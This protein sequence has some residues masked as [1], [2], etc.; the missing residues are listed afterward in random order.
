MRERQ[1]KVSL[2]VHHKSPKSG[3]II[4]TTPYRLV[5]VGNQRYYEMPTGSGSFF[6]ENAKPV[7]EANLPEQCKRLPA[8]KTPLSQEQEMAKMRE[9]LN[10]IQNENTELAQAKER[11]EAE[12]KARDSAQTDSKPASPASPVTPK[13]KTA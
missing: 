12:A 9:V 11:L 3:K 5:C 8:V 13:Q 7:P 4:H 1:E 6:Y 10:R 2:V